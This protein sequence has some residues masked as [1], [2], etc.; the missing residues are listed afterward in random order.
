MIA[1]DGSVT[2]VIWS[3][4]IESRYKRSQSVLRQAVL[5]KLLRGA[6]GRPA[7]SLGSDSEPAGDELRLPH[8]IPSV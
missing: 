7:L 4:P 5:R 8:R 2:V 1:P 3:H 6:K